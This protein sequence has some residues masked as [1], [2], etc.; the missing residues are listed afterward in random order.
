MA[1]AT[2]PVSAPTASSTV[3]APA[4][5]TGNVHPRDFIT[6]CITWITVFAVLVVLGFGI[7]NEIQ[8]RSTPDSGKTTAAKI[9]CQ[10]ASAYETRGCQG[11]VGNTVWTEKIK[12]AEGSAAN[13]MMLCYTPGVIHEQIQEAGTTWWRFKAIGGSVPLQYRFFPGDQSCPEK[14][15]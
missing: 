11:P 13:G 10:D 1:R 6:K 3:G 8:K 14:M 15:P 9:V 4:A 5:T 12:A 7:T 2:T